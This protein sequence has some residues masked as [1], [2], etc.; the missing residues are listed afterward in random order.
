M[1]RV[2]GRP[3][4]EYILDNFKEHDVNLIIVD[5]KFNDIR[6]YCAKRYPDTSFIKQEVMDGPHD[7]ILL[8]LNHSAYNESIPTVVWLGDT[9]V[10]DQELPLGT[11]FLLVK[12][13]VTDHSAWCMWDGEEFFN[14]PKENIEKGKALV[15]VY[16]FEDGSVCRSSF[17]VTKGSYEISDALKMARGF[18][19]A[20][21]KNWYDIGQLDSY[22]KTCSELLKRKARSFNRLEFNTKLGVVTKS[23]D[24]SD[25]HSVRAIAAE[26]QWYQN[27]NLGERCFVPQYFED[28]S[29]ELE[30]TLRYE[31]ASIL[32]DILLYDDLSEGAIRNILSKI[33]EIKEE[34]FNDTCV[35]KG[36]VTGFSDHL[37]LMWEVKAASRLNACEKIFKAKELSRLKEISADVMK[38]AKPIQVMLGDLHSGNILYSIHDNSVKFID[39]RG[40]YGHW[41]TTC[42]DDIYDYAK[43]AHD[44]YWGY[45]AAVEDTKQCEKAKKVFV[46]LLEEHGQDVSVILE[47]GLL[48]L[49][50]C[51]PL[52]SDDPKRQERFAKIV[53][54]GLNEIDS[55]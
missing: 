16:S 12:E 52:H 9:I 45:T 6:E 34:H 35:D 41:V 5:G 2:N 55:I 48:L 20:I 53:K 47:A 17:R 21:A 10:V 23:P 11:D 22:Y 13:N 1:V 37:S 46:E 28:L 27:I 39:P 36:F 29:T 14:K 25:T 30:L 19:Y 33:F 26:I 49:A 4:L 44:L 24:Y 40:E 8:G 7:A 32:Q 42:G 3:C 18:G 51:I 54:R 43:L 15:G 31:N 38:H 50:T